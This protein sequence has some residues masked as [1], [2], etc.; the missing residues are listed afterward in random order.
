MDMSHLKYFQTVAKYE[1]MSRAANELHIAQPSISKAISQLENDLGTPL[2]DRCGR[3]IKLNSFGLAF[4]RRVDRILLEFEDGKKEISDM[5]GREKVK[6]SFGTN[7]IYLV[8]SIIKG[9]F[10]QNPHINLHQ[11]I[12]STAEMQRKLE[13]GDID[14][15]ISSPP[16]TGQGI[17]CVSLMTEEIYLMVP[18][19]HKLANL[20]SI[21]LSEAANEPFISI[22]E[23]YGLRD[24]TNDFCRKAGFT[25]NIIFEGDVAMISISL[26]NAGMGVALLPRP[27][28]I[29]CTNGYSL[30]LLHVKKPSCK[31]TIGLSSI[32]DRRLTQAAK[33]FKDYIIDFMKF[34]AS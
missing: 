21:N 8:P 22:K 20:K 28:W 27:K 3:Q 7:Q 18:W 12:G 24:M 31:R 19:Q 32:R 29:N 33:Q 26:V 6:V 23:G 11:S 14:F 10:T 17:E 30:S 15:C 4:L 34:P 25:P 9:F 13:N 16:I 2:F 5:V 1:H